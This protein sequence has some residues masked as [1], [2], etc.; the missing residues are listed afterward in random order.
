MMAKGHK[1]LKHFS[2]HSIISY[3]PQPGQATEVQVHGLPGCK[4]SCDLHMEHL[5]PLTM[6]SLGANKKAIIRVGK[7]VALLARITKSFDEAVGVSQPRS[8]HY[9]K[10]RG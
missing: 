2:S 4:V 5:N 10:F 1:R 3:S 9:G 6:E 7:A 8:K